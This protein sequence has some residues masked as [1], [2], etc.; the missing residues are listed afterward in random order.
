M[1]SKCLWKMFSCDDSVRGNYT[2][3]ELDDLLDSLHD[4]VESLPQYKDTRTEPVLEP[5]IKI[6]SVVHKLVRRGHLSVRSFSLLFMSFD[7][8]LRPI[9]TFRSQPKE[10][11]LSRKAIW[12]GMF[13]HRKA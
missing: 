9:L 2:R 10:A 6:L 13:S 8:L 4:A 5:H 7:F 12:H 1:L 11:K 3:V